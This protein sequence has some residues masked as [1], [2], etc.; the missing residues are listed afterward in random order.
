MF[1]CII[2]L[3]SLAIGKQK[4][5]LFIF[6]LITSK[7]KK[8]KGFKQAQYFLIDGTRYDKYLRGFEFCLTLGFLK[9]IRNMSSVVQ[10]HTFHGN[11]LKLILHKLKCAC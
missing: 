11:I 9:M 8:H 2:V 3:L 10:I 1:I 5:F 4:M 7:M 6:V